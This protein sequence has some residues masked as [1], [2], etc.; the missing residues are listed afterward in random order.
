[1][2]GTAFFCLPLRFAIDPGLCLIHNRALPGRT[3]GQDSA[4]DMTYTLR[5]LPEV[6]ADALAAHLWYEE[7]KQ[8]L[9]EEL[10]RTFY[11]SVSD[12][13]SNPLLFEKAYGRFRRCMLRRFP[14]VVYFTVQEGKVVVYGLFHSARDPHFISTSLQER[15][16]DE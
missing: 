11:S 15:N 13:R 2:D 5:F 4:K 9:G 12:I 7:K 6:E 16:R 8:G 1:M 10:L 3:S 14:Y